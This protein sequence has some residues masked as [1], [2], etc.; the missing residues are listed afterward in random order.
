MKW[1]KDLK[2]KSVKAVR[3]LNFQRYFAKEQSRL[4]NQGLGQTFANEASAR[5]YE[6]GVEGKS[7][8][9]S[10]FGDKW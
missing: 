4:I 7:F 8:T 5:A 10:A 3:T 6:M 2:P 1:S 9:E